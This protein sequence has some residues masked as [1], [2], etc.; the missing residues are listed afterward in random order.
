MVTSI[1]AVFSTAST[2]TAPNPR[3]AIV[4]IFPSFY[5]RFENCHLSVQYYQNCGQSCE[6]NKCADSKYCHRI[7][8]LFILMLF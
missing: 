6:C 8:L 5:F 3:S 2:A 7:F 1:S 4:I